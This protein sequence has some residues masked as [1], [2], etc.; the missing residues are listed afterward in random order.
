M[1]N[2]N[3]SDSGGRRNF[4]STVLSKNIYKSL[5]KLNV[6]DIN[7]NQVEKRMLLKVAKET[8]EAP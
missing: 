4:W 6:T 1:E 3:K 8:E 5:L 7:T 2:M